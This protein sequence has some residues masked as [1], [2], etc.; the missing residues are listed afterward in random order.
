[1]KEFFTCTIG[2]LRKYKRLWVVNTAFVAIFLIGI[3]SILFAQPEL[4]VCCFFLLIMISWE[5][6]DV[7][8]FEKQSV[9][10]AEL[11][12]AQDDLIVKE[13]E[14]ERLTSELETAQAALIEAK[15]PK[16]NHSG[17]VQTG[18]SQIESGLAP[19][20]ASIDTAEANDLKSKRKPAPRGTRKP[21]TK[22]ENKN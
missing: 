12:D 14:V 21:K 7:F 6:S 15:K 1:M 9:L 4:I 2:L 3:L 18:F 20:T 8:L 17:Y 16:K 11:A 13:H 19:K 5:M 10:Q 22:N